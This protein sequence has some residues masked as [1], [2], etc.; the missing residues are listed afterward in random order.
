MVTNKADEQFCI[1]ACAPADEL[2]PRIEGKSGFGGILSPVKGGTAR[3]V[4]KLDENEV[5]S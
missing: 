4:V 1:A 3:G 2:N 5:E